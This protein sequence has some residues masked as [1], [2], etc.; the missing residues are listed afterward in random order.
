[1]FLQLMDLATAPTRWIARQMTAGARLAVVGL[2]VALPLGFVLNAYRTDKG[3][4]VAFSARERDGVA[5]LVPALDLLRTSA[6]IRVGGQGDLKQAVSATQAA[7][8]FD[9]NE[10]IAAVTGADPVAAALVVTTEIGNRSNLVLDPDLDSFWVMDAAVVKATTFID[11]ASKLTT[12]LASP[13]PSVPDIA[14]A[15]G[16][17]SS[18]AAALDV[19]LTTSVAVTADSQLAGDIDGPKR[20]LLDDIGR[21]VAL[22]NARINGE[23]VTQG[24]VD[25]AYRAVV[26]SEAAFTGS[27]V[28]ALDRLLVTRIDGFTESRRQA[29]LV[30]TLGV[31]LAIWLLIGMVRQNRISSRPLVNAFRLAVEGQLQAPGD[32]GGRDELAVLSRSYSTVSDRLGTMIDGVSRQASDLAAMA[33]RLSEVASEL[34]RRVD[35]TLDRSTLLASAAE[36]MTVVANDFAHDTDRARHSTDEAIG[37]SGVA[38]TAA[39]DLENDSES[40]GRVVSMIGEIAAQTNLLALNASIEAA[41]A[42]EH[43]RGFSVVAGEVKELAAQSGDAAEQVGSLVAQIRATSSIAAREVLSIGTAL[44]NMDEL[45]SVL[46]AAAN[47]Q[48]ATAHEVAEVAAGVAGSAERTRASSSELVAMSAELTAAGIELDQ[49]LG[50]FSRR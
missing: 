27:A 7:D 18:N 31:G 49:L 39:E 28:V 11:Q 45:Y 32:P 44:H 1:M 8:T 21:L 36:E 26:T 47:E 37:L 14:L 16:A 22:G 33:H 3:A 43:G 50:A 24:E 35:E 41:R 30:T 29:M 25:E 48:S 5:A 4:Q 6:K 20:Q 13:V 19:G 42:G 2:A 46:S 17:L 12:L 10:E 38:R 15:A 9:L 34:D 40:V 23:A